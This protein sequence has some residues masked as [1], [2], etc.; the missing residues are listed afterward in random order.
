VLPVKA[1]PGAKRN[2]VSG[3]HNGMLK[4]SVCQAPE[5]GKANRAVAEVL[6]EEL[7]LRAAQLQ[8]I[9]GETSAQKRFLVGGIPAQELA[10][11]IAAVLSALAKGKR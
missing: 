10:Q 5:K 7:G 1:Q 11:R 3:E 4:V 8:L 2:A 9:A 6:C